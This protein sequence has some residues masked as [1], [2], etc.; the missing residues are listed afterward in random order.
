MSAGL[1]VSREEFGTVPSRTDTYLLAEL[2][3]IASQN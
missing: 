1:V 2:I 3:G